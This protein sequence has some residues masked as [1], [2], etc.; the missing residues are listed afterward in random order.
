MLNYIWAGMILVGI[1]AAAFC[2]KMDAVTNAA[3]QSA[4]DAVN[5][6][7]TMLGVIAMWSGLLKIC[8]VSGLTKK[9][10]KKIMPFLRW[11]FPD[12]PPGSRAMEYISENVI[13]NVMGV[14]WAATPAGLKAMGELQRL[15]PKKDTASD[16]MCMFLIFN[17]SSLQLVCINLIAYRMQYN[18]ANPGEIIGPGIFATLVSTL[19]GIIFAK[20]AEAAH[21]S[22]KKW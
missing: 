19:S 4:R 2:G 6:A 11:L 12:V 5:V 10:T 3:V 7:I 8:E 22:C 21:R 20:C 15:N 16:A 9:I 1:L 13:A 14:S 17:M 18:S